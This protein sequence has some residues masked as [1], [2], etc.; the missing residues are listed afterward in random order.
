MIRSVVFD[1]DGTLFDR[2]TSL[3]RCLQA[4][5]GRF[6]KLLSGV[7]EADF[8]RRFREL[9]ARGYVRKD[10]VYQQLVSEYGLPDST[11]GILFDDFYAHYHE[12]AVG[13]P[14]LRVTLEQLRS[15]G[16]TLGITTNGRTL[17]QQ[18]TMRALEI[19]S[20]FDVILISEAEGFRKPDA[21]I[22]R[23]GLARLGL[24]ADEVVFVG[25][26]PEVDVAGARA[27][28]MWSV[29]RRDVYWGECEDAHAVIDELSELPAL[30]TAGPWLTANSPR[31][32]A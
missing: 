20:Y 19:E 7:R 11:A 25:D 26:H 9:D 27:A 32:G 30:L 21:R 22:F 16:L 1:L 4:Q 17:H 29:W 6:A 8:G 13:F 31:V 28:G 15:D 12:H 24:S 18:R 5:H 2:A 3:D 23:R 14:D 10:Q